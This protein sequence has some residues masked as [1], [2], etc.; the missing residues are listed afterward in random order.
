M[1]RW[2]DDELM[3]NEVFRAACVLGRA[4]PGLVPAINRL[5]NSAV[6]TR[7]YSDWSDRVFVASRTVRFRE[8]EYA[9]PAEALPEVVRHIRAFID[10]R[11]LQIS[12][13][14][15]LRFAA[16]DNLMLSTAH[17][18]A[19]GYVAVHRYFRHDYREYFGGVEEICRAVGGRPHWGK[20]HTQTADSLRWLYPRFDEFVE[21]RD[22]LD[23]SRTFA[24]DHLRRVL[25][26]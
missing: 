13:P 22:R 18:R 25:G 10:R 15:E 14:I 3:S 24:N 1:R 17:G 12:F 19:T 7:T 23:P 2:L 5:A 11:D 16:A 21:V 8:Q 26:A 9:V 4:A 6:A 20:V